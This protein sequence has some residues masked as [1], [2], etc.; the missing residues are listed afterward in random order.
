MGLLSKSSLSSVLS[1]TS[2]VPSKTSGLSPVPSQTSGLSP[3]MVVVVG[4]GPAST[5]SFLVFSQR[6]TKADEKI[7]ENQKLKVNKR[8]TVKWLMP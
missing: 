5:F 4:C 6:E 8:S 3:S 2:P 1:K 7:D